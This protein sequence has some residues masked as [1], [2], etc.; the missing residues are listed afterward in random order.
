MKRRNFLKSAGGAV[1]ALML[2]FG[3][4]VKLSAP[5]KAK[6]VTLV[7]FW[8][9]TSRVSRFCDQAYLDYLNA[10]R[11]DKAF[12]ASL[13]TAICRLRERIETI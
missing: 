6:A 1:A 10:L 2:P 11:N 3:L 4:N 9:E 5:K 13:E 7:P 12:K 8:Y